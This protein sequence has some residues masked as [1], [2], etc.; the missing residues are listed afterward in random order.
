MVNWNNAKASGVLRSAYHFFDPTIDGVA[1]ANFFLSQL[2]NDLGELP[3]MLDLECPTSSN[4]AAA[5]S[6]CE[7]AGDSGWVQS[8]V[9]QKRALDWLSTVASAVGRRPIVYSYPSWFSNVGVTDPKLASYPLFIAIYSSCASVPAPWATAAF[10]QY[11]NN[12][13]VPG[14]TS[15]TDLDRWLG[16]QAELTAFADCVEAGTCAPVD[17]GAGGTGGATGEV[18]GAGG[19]AGTAG[20]MNASGGGGGAGVAGAMSGNGGGAGTAGA[21]NGTGGIAGAA[22]AMSGAAGGATGG[23]SGTSGVN[24]GG[25]NGLS[26]AGTS[27]ASGSS[28]ASGNSSVAGAAGAVS[29]VHGASEDGGAAGTGSANAEFAGASSN[30]NMNGGCGCHVAGSSSRGRATLSLVIAGIAVGLRRRK[31]SRPHRES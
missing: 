14:I 28:D 10:W 16:T 22:G 5:Q 2:G 4:Q 6:D 31:R 29:G 18:S 7:Y 25:N 30:K 9:V 19:I 23:G 8:S 24:T 11:S 27:G 17:A 20:A 3:P 12:G 1:Q 21:M 13:T 26:G 15:A